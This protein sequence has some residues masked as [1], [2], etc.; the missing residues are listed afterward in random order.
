MAAAFATVTE[1]MATKS[2][3]KSMVMLVVGLNWVVGVLERHP[4]SL[5]YLLSY[6]LR[7]RAAWCWI[8]SISGTLPSLRSASK[9]GVQTSTFVGLPYLPT[10]HRLLPESFQ[11]I[12]H[13]TSPLS[14]LPSS[15]LVFVLSVVSFAT[16]SPRWESN[17]QPPVPSSKR[18]RGCLY[19][20][21]RGLTAQRRSQIGLWGILGRHSPLP[22]LGLDGGFVG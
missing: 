16:F 12:H 18:P 3:E 2:L 14:Q 6:F 22:L 17:L 1:R 5:L 20:H 13:S 15:F 4:P 9:I 7:A 19:W 11:S 21:W 10:A 8:H